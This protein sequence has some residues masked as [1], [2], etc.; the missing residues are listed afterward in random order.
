[1]GLNGLFSEPL[2]DQLIESW[3][4]EGENLLLEIFFVFCEEVV[5][6]V[7]IDQRLFFDFVE[8]RG[9]LHYN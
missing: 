3:K 2:L 6:G 7:E 9:F 5:G 4:K 1:M 8:F